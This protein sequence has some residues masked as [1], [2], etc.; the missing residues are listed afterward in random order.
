MLVLKLPKSSEDLEKCKGF[1]L[2]TAGLAAYVT[3]GLLA[4]GIKALEGARV[5][6]FNS[7]FLCV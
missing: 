1:A 2:G 3:A 5:W 6:A 4:N 7:S